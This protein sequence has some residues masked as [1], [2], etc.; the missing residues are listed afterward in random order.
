MNI[1]FAKFIAKLLSA[2]L[3]CM[4]IKTTEFSRIFEIVYATGL[5]WDTDYTRQTVEDQT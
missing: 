4:A 5:D 2:S 1:L 3:I